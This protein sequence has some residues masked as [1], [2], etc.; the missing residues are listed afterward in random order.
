MKITKKAFDEV[1]TEVAGEDV[2][3]LVRNM[4]SRKNISEFKLSENIKM[5]INHVRNMLY[6][7]YNVNLVSFIRKKDKTKGWYIYYWTFNKDRIK[8]L[9]K[10]TKKGKLDQ[11]KERVEREK[12]SQYFICKS[13]CIR[14]D[15]E[16]ATEFLYK[17]PECGSLLQE[18]N[19]SEKI[20]NLDMEIKRLEKEIKHVR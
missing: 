7:L 8:E 14:L 18:E 2:L 13:R 11:L 19:N 4:G 15:F 9:I 5:E 6:R 17:C 20:K 12:S 10:S 1:I 3:P 16:Q